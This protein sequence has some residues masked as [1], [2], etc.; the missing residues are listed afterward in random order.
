MKAAETLDASLLIAKGLVAEYLSDG[1][2]RPSA[3]IT[4]MVSFCI[5]YFYWATLWLKKDAP[6][7]L[8]G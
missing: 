1:K 7:I 6:A 4:Y 8:C 3:I 2:V 5:S